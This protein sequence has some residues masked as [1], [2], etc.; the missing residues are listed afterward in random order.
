MDCF[1]S[2]P[3]PVAPIPALYCLILKPPP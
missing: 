2:F 1:P 3:S